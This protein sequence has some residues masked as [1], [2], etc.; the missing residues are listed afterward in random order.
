MQN[1]KKSLFEVRF[2]FLRCLFGGFGASLGGSV[3]WNFFPSFS[4]EHGPFFQNAGQARKMQKNHFFFAEM[5]YTHVGTK[6]IK[7]P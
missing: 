7:R 2:G 4:L 6:Y 1:G 3:F 5:A